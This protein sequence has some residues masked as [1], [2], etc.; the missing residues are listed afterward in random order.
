M[1]HTNTLRQNNKLAIAVIMVA[2][3]VVGIIAGGSVLQA[4]RMPAADGAPQVQPA[5]TPTI[6]GGLCGAETN[7][8]QVAKAVG[9]SVVSVWNL[10]RPN[11]GAEPKRVGLG[12]GLVVSSD[13]MILT[14]QH[15]VDGAD[16]VDV[17]LVSGK[18]YAAQILGASPVVDIAILKI[19]A[20]GLRVVTLGDSDDLQVGQQAIAIGNPLGFEHTVT[21]GVVSALN[22]IIPEGGASLRDLIQTD[23][24]INPGNSGGPLLDSC[25]RVIGINTAVVTGDQGVGGLGFAIPINVGRQAISDVQKY[26]RIITPWIGIGYAPITPDVAAA[27]KLPVSEGVIVGS[28]VPNSPAAK[29]G[30]RKGDIITSMNG[31]P[32]EDGSVIQ[33]FIR[34]AKIG[35][36]MTFKLLRDG[37]EKTITVTVEEM[38]SKLALG[39]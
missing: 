29:A 22:R 11:P 28:V 18:T 36:K 35:D 37:K 12:S 38:P 2:L 20:S 9:P 33:E 8:I 26:G 13:G 32:V 16:R 30:I 23:A 25:G 34:S 7:I 15:V 31:K 19:P 27:F 24:S 39:D 5:V 14:N 17:V 4:V 3:F 21:V 10:Q 6:A 1:L